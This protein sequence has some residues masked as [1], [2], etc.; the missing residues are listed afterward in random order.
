MIQK[1]HYMER[2]SHDWSNDS[3]RIINTPSA[4]AKSIYFYMQETGYFKTR[5]PYFTER[6]NLNSFLIVYTIAGKG[7]LLYDNFEYTLRPGQCFFIHC[8]N[9]HYYETLQNCEWE[10]LWLHF[11]GN[12]ALGYYNEFIKNGFMIL[13]IQDTFHFEST[14]RRIVAMNQKK[15]IS[16]EIMT[17]NLIINLLT[18]LL[19]QNCIPTTTTFFLPQY[20][21]EVL[22][23][24]E[25]NFQSPL[26]L[27]MLASQQ[28]ISK[29]HL[30]KEFKKYTGNTVNEYIINT[31]LSYAKELLKYSD[32][33]IR[34]I[35]YAC[36][37]NNISHF[38][39]LF[40]S[41]ERMTP[42]AYRKE[43]TEH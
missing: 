42:L 29:F 3:I 43:W 12:N 31:R 10:F 13:D 40:K 35:T 39:N 14:L 23:T 24:I 17:S 36:G 7:N 15:N 28:N 19:I 1:N 37:M 27:D 33:P 4:T 16:T 25:K 6:A 34:E 11:N 8:M 21:K 30:A 18:E 9:H 26:S 5:Y 20:I 41:R 22:K 2:A 38:I 32:L